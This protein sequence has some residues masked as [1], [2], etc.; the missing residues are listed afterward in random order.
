[1]KSDATLFQFGGN[2]KKLLDIARQAIEFPDDE[3]IF[4]PQKLKGS[5]ELRTI[6]RSS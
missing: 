4:G 6:F 5:G 1:L 2:L 3:G